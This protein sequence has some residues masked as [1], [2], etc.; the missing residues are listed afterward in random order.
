MPSSCAGNV[1]TCTG[2][3]EQSMGA[4]NR[5]GIGFC[6]TAHCKEN[7][8][9]VFLFWELRRLSPNFHIH[10][11]VGDLYIPR[12]I[13]THTVFPCSRIADRSW[14]NIN[15]SKIYECRNWVTEHYNSVLEITVSFLGI[16][17]RDPDLY[18][19]FSLALFLQ[20][21]PPGYIV[22]SISVLLKSLT[23]PSLKGYTLKV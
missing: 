3:L 17:K 2:I 12:I 16:H 23:I 8:I 4:K 19:G 20:C 5:A 7:P 1:D 10:V 22:E 15:L 11:S 21:G 14:K 9:Y 18:I 13:G 6:R